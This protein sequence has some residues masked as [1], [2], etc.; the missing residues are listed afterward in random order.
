[1]THVI[2]PVQISVH[3]SNPVSVS[4][5]SRSKRA[6]KQVT[7]VCL[8]PPRD[9][10]LL[11]TFISLL[12]LKTMKNQYTELEYGKGSRAPDLLTGV[13]VLGVTLFMYIRAP[14]QELDLDFPFTGTPTERPFPLPEPVRIGCRRLFWES[15]PRRSPRSCGSFTSR[16]QVGRRGRTQTLL[17]STKTRRQGKRSRNVAGKM[18]LFGG[19]PRRYLSFGNGPTLHHRS[20][21]L[22]KEENYGPLIK[23]L[24][25][26]ESQDW[27]RRRVYTQ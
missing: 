12:K 9:N 23:T 4:F 7:S 3:V 26:S 11:S 5:T 20:P 19:L 6:Y 15:R 17:S 13:L 18:Y 22:A 21:Y 2:V 24:V 25:P 16:E 8:L 14:T 1:M 10:S 27:G